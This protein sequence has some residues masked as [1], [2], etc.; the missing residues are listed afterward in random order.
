MYTIGSIYVGVPQY[1]VVYISSKYNMLW[2]VTIPTSYP[3]QKPEH[4][5]ALQPIMFGFFYAYSLYMD[6][7]IGI[8]YII[9][10]GYRH[11]LLK[12]AV[13]VRKSELLRKDMLLSSKIS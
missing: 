6:C 1:I 13:S 5:T 2:G 10:Q 12:W 11:R 8:V 7:I 4:S 3:C 9:W